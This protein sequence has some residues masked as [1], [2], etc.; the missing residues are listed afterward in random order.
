MSEI[1]P[2]VR[3]TATVIPEIN[4]ASLQYEFES[5]TGYT[6]KFKLEKAAKLSSIGEF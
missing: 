4:Q 6:E 1:T 2:G 5:S 3:I